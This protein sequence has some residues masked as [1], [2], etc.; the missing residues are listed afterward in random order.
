MCEIDEISGH[1]KLATLERHFDQN[2]AWEKTWT[3]KSMVS[4]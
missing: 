2:A 1:R 4:Q 3:G